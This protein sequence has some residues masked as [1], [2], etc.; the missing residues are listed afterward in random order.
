MKKLLIGSLVAAIILFIWQFLSWQALQ[1]HGA[2]TQHTMNQQKILPVLS[3]NL[4]EGQYMLVTVPEGTGG[5]QMMDP[6]VIEAMTGNPWATVN[7]HPSFEM[8]M[9]MNLLRGFVMDFLAAFLLVWVLLKMSN[10]DFRTALLTSVAIGFIGYFTIP[11]LNHIWYETD[12][13]GY[14]IDAVVGW[15]LV[16]AWLGWYLN[17][18]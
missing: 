17:R 11:Y 15:G 9:G 7:Y 16:G 18:G 14:L 12:T 3:E 6:E 1:L 8:N 5:D 10:L 13:I 4:E 2:E